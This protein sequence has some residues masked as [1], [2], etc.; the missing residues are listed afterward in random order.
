MSYPL[1][2]SILKL[3]GWGILLTL[4]VVVSVGTG[5]V[6]LEFTNNYRVFFS[7]DNPQLQ[8]FDQFQEIYGDQDNILIAIE[9]KDG[10][11]F[12]KET[13]S[14]INDFT[15]KAWE[16]PYSKR[17]DSLANF[18]HTFSQND[19]LVV[20]YLVENN[21]DLTPARVKEIRDIVMGDPILTG[22]LIS[23]KG[24]VTALNITMNLPP[25]AGSEEAEAIAY[26]RN[27]AQKMEEANPNIKTY[28]SGQTVLNAAF[29]EAAFAD[30]T[31]LIPAM[32]LL[33]I[34]VTYLFLRSFW[35]TV[36]TLMVVTLSIVVAFGGAGYFGITQTN[37]TGMVP[38]IILTLGVAD[39]I[40]L[41]ITYY[42]EVN[43]GK[44][45]HEA[46]VEAMR[47]NM[48]PIFL[49]SLTTIIGFLSLNFSE[50]PP[51]RDMGNMVAMGTAAAWLISVVTLPLL[52]MMLP[53]K[54]KSLSESTEYKIMGG[55]YEFV[56]QNRKALLVSFV[57]GLGVMGAS[58]PRIEFND[59]FAEYFDKS[60]QFRADNDFIIENLTGVMA[61]QYSVS[62]GEE[63]GIYKPEY[64]SQLDAFGI[65][66]EQQEQVLYVNKITT[67]IKRLNKNLHNDDPEY[68]RI[69]TDRQLAAQYMFLYELSLPY[70]LDLSNAMDVD[71]SA[72]RLTAVIKNTKSVDV[73]KL[74]EDA[75]N[76]LKAN[77]PDLIVS[78]AV[79]PSIMFSHISERNLPSMVQG[80]V[81]AVVLISGV[82]LVALKNIKLG[83]LSLIPNLSPAILA[84]GV[85][86]LSIGELG[87]TGISITVITLGII[88]D[89][90]VHFLSKYLRAKTEMNK[91]VGE[92]I[93]YAF[94]TVGIA[95]GVTT[96][97]L[98]LGFLVLSFSKF[99]PNQVLGQLTALSLFISLM[100]TYFF[101]PPLLFFLNPEKK[102]DIE[103]DETIDIKEAA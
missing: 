55:L 88:V 57:I 79:G 85:W 47:I 29:M 35:G 37:A 51:F 14:V 100:V 84:Y 52:M 3:K 48:Q 89:N 61:L 68:Y 101:L 38:I 16:T 41:L 10:N 8:D 2:E 93:E 56:E 46:M 96:T 83:L 50:I 19:D 75:R 82:L 69:P 98:V 21:D 23:E 66:F 30:G 7:E 76:W 72:T 24:H 25:D 70:G 22:M 90:T 32:F 63:Q 102:D 15:D 81:L 64:L 39:S 58:I 4:L 42:H 12:S 67:I 18:Q 40:H 9:A 103:R 44:S 80:L 65:W 54:S 20:E 74:D 73:I 62:A 1:G 5:A 95:L 94:K 28:I 53:V 11:I 92:A 86:A 87:M 34:I 49:T 91:T 60:M 99:Q 27:L 17:V 45:K 59:L 77:A 26:V 13:L 71:R 97:I 78:N 33:I 31:T 6:S 36:G 43:H